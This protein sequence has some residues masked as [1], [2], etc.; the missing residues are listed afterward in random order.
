MTARCA[1]LCCCLGALASG[2]CQSLAPRS[3][4]NACQIKC[5]SLAEQSQAQLAEIAVLK[6]H[7]RALEDRLIAAER[8]D[9]Q[10]K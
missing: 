3:Q 6:Q 9:T 7:N 1:M 8:R 10:A 5:R 2:G 4:L